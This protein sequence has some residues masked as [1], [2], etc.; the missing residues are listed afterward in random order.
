AVLE[1]ARKISAVRA[2][3]VHC[4]TSHAH[5]LGALAARL[6]G[7]PA[8]I[9]SR[10]VDFSIYRN[11][12]FGLNGIKYRAG[13]DRI[14]CVSEAVRDVLVRDGLRPERLRVVRSAVD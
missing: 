5:T 12:F 6:A 14:V 11:S 7:R 13:V 2:D 3:V 4:H 10:R 1:L 8:V 9:V